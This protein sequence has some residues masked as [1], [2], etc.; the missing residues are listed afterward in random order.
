MDN[1]TQN[2]MLEKVLKGSRRLLSYHSYPVGTYM[3]KIIAECET[4]D[5]DSVVH[6][7]VNQV[8]EEASA[9]TNFR[10]DNKEAVGCEIEGIEGPV[11]FHFYDN[12]YKISLQV[13]D[14]G[15]SQ[16]YDLTK[17]YENKV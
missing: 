10:R 15:G 11:Y 1:N 3:D 12:K 9:L 16:T 8:L 13:V 17:H 5:S 2:E 6:K 14:R 4:S 7:I